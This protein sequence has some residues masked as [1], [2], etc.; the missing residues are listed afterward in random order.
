VARK[1]KSPTHEATTPAYAE[2]E[3][4]APDPPEVDSCNACRY[5]KPASSGLGKC[6]RSPPAV[7]SG[8]NVTHAGLGGTW[9][10]TYADQWC[11]EFARSSPLTDPAP[12]P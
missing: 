6:R 2:V 9:P 12:V 4:T 3:T 8:I 11:G 10:L 5:W 7:V 1:K